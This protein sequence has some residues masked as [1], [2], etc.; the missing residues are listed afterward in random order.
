MMNIELLVTIIAIP[1]VNWLV[2]RV[3]GNTGWSGEVVLALVSIFVGFAYGVFHYMVPE[4]LQ[5]SIMEFVSKV[6]FFAVLVYEF[7]LKR[8]SGDK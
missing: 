8:L 4:V 6:G 3:K 2:M 7:L 1:L 5:Q